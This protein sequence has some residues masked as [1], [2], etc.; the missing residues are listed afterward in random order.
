[1]GGSGNGCAQEMPLQFDRSGT[2]LSRFH[3][4]DV[5]LCNVIYRLKLRCAKL[6]DSYQNSGVIKSKGP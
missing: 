2:F 1:M 5:V 6:R 3:Q 4:Q